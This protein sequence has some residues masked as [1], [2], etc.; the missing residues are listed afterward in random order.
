MIHYDRIGTLK[1]GWEGESAD[2]IC[3]LPLVSVR[4][5]T[6]KRLFVVVVAMNAVSRDERDARG[7]GSS[8]CSS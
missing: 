3:Y 7:G 2:D 8:G 5:G 4:C 1:S 6:S